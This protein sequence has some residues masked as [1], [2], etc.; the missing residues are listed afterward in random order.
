MPTPAKPCDGRLNDELQPILNKNRN[1]AQ[2]SEYPCAVCGLSV[3]VIEIK[4]T[5][6]PKPH[7][8]SINYALRKAGKKTKAVRSVVDTAQPQP[9]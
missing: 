1:R 4:G 8:P 5:W 7:W 9:E 3:E 6:V 2:W